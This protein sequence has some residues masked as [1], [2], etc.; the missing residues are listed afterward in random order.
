M[1]GD[2][3]IAQIVLQIITL[4]SLTLVNWGSRS[5]RYIGNIQSTFSEPCWCSS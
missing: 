4:Y 3:Y 1:H 5:Q 2:R